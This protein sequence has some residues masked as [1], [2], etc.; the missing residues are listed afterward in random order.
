VNRGEDERVILAT[1]QTQL[2]AFRV[3]RQRYLLYPQ[4]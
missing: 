1:G 2:E 4:L 3:L